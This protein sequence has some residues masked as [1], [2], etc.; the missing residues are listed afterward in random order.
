M[1][2]FFDAPKKSLR[3]LFGKQPADTVGN[4]PRRFLQAFLEHGVEASQIPRLL[5]QIKLDDVQSPEKLLAALTPEILDQTAQLFGI[6]SQWLE[7]IEDQIYSGFY[8]YKRPRALLNQVASLCLPDDQSLNFPLR[9]L[10]TTLNLDRNNSAQQLLIPI[11]VERIAELGEEEIFRYHIYTDGFDWSYF[12]TR[13]ELKAIAR[14][15]YKK[16]RIGVPMY[17]VSPKQ[18]EDILECRTIPRRYLK[19]SLLTTPSLEDFALSEEESSVAKEV[20]ELPA[21]LCYIETHDL[22]SFS[23]ARA[24]ESAPVQEP[25]SAASADSSSP[26]PA[27]PKAKPLRP[28]QLDKQ[29]CQ[30][31]AK[32]LWEQYPT[33]TIAE[34]YR[35]AEIRQAGGKNYQEKTLRTWLSPVAPPH[36]RAKRGRPKKDEAT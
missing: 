31:A 10:A 34:M 36:V 11:V 3:H 24:D 7:G 18:I 1:S 20:E 14:L 29:L 33:M 12:P 17:V 32:K 19:G 30:D 6:R 4:V 16:L 26:P 13:I 25:E 27:P 15:V 2:S 5:P 35:R 22:Q 8:A 28:E 21:V 23:F 9:V